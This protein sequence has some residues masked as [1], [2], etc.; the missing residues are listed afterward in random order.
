MITYKA[1]MLG[2]KVELISEAYTSS[3]CPICGSINHT[4]NR[5][6]KCANCGFEYHRDG[7]GAIS[8]WKRYL[9]D[10]AQVVAELASVRGVRYHSHLCGHG[11]STDPWKVA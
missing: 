5:N 3:I 1:Q 6:Y 8:I 4:N 2:I 7:V 9:G 10:K 11:V